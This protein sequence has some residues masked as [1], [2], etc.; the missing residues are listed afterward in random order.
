MDAILME[1]IESYRFNED[2]MNTLLDDIPELP[3][4]EDA[5]ESAPSSTPTANP[6]TTNTSSTN[7]A[8]GNTDANKSTADNG[9][10]KEEGDKGPGLLE[11][12]KKLFQF[13][14]DMV[15]KL[16]VN[17]KEKMQYSLTTKKAYEQ[18]VRELERKYQPRFDLIKKN[19][20]YDANILQNV[21]R[22]FSSLFEEYKG[23]LSTIVDEYKRV[24]DGNAETSQYNEKVK[25]LSEK[26]LHTNIAKTFAS[27]LG[28]EFNRVESFTQLTKGIQQK[29]RGVK[30][31]VDEEGNATMEK[32][33][34]SVEMTLDA[35]VYND[36]K[37]FINNFYT[38]ITNN[39][40]MADSI[41]TY[42]KTVQSTMENIGTHSQN[43][44]AKISA[45]AILKMAKGINFFSTL[46]NFITSLYVER[47]VNA[48]MVVKA[49]L[50][51]DGDVKL[52][53]R[54]EAAGLKT[55]IPNKIEDAQGY[56]KRKF[57][58]V[59]KGLRKVANTII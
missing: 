52:K 16:I 23:D 17:I 14:Q 34:G 9:E 59:K 27:K 8:T 56:A 55:Q 43:K 3:A 45:S 39:H 47:L 19:R 7:A 48:R 26:P 30:V 15:T 57:N 25:Q 33:S 53:T 6:S 21:M 13:L 28:P 18:E 10:A 50:G 11:K 54:E 46:L 5:S 4:M 32:G 42:Q 31:N 24:T 22:T 58:D 44:D 35:T 40:K 2:L 49:C 36:C 51:G 29:F 1:A 12:I 38:L 41:K 37:N 20:R